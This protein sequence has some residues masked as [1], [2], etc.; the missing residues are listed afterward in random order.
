MSALQETSGIGNSSD[1]P[2]PN[3]EV[4]ERT[5]VYKA[6]QIPS[7][8]TDLIQSWRDLIVGEKYKICNLHTFTRTSKRNAGKIGVHVF[9]ESGYLELPHRFRE[10]ADYFAKH[11]PKNF[12][13]SYMGRRGARN[14]YI[15]HF[16]DDE[17]LVKLKT[18]LKRNETIETNTRT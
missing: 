18:N 2:T 5:N 13:M 16:Y 1:V 14:A 6:T 15:I 17:K 4:A 10:I 8:R 3:L 9:L 12:Y 7:D 11:R